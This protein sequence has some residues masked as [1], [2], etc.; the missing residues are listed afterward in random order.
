MYQQVNCEV[1]A[2]CKCIIGDRN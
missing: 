2:K 1:Q